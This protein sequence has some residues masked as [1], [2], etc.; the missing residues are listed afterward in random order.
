MVFGGSI[1]IFTSSG[2]RGLR[3]SG[4]RRPQTSR[5]SVRVSRYSIT[6]TDDVYSAR[7]AIWTSV[8]ECIPRSLDGTRKSMGQQIQSTLAAS[9]ISSWV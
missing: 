9:L 4:Q 6:G 5:Q 1:A 8:D 3:C 7:Y 2:I